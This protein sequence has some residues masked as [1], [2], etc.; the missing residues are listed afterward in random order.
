MVENVGYPE[1][2]MTAEVE[3]Y[4][5]WPGQATSYKIGMLKLLEL[6]RRAI[7]ALGDRFDIKAF[8]NLVLTNGAMPLE[9]LERVVDDFI[10]DEL[11]Q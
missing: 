10:A 2:R 11:S 4:I 6:R 3:R 5:A 1:S 8:H 7:D 9:I